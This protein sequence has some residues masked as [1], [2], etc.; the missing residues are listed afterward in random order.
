MVAMGFG[1]RLGVDLQSVSRQVHLNRGCMT[2]FM[3]KDDGAPP[4]SSLSQSDKAK[5]S[6]Y[7]SSTRT[8]LLLS[9]IEDTS[10]RL[11]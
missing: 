6:L 3:A 5:Y 4:L 10:T 9:P 8:T 2:R 11:M 7:A 1:Y